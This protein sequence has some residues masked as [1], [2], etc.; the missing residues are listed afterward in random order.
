MVRAP[1]SSTRPLLDPILRMLNAGPHPALFLSGLDI[2][3]RHLDRVLNHPVALKFQEP[4]LFKDSV[5]ESILNALLDQSDYKQCL[6]ML[7]LLPLVMQF[8]LNDMGSA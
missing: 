6:P 1:A 7:R 2:L 8:K 4:H 3:V 5:I